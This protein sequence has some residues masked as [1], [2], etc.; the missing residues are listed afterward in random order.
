MDHRLVGVRSA[1]V[2]A[3]RLACSS[4]KKNKLLP[5]HDYEM[6][7]DVTRSRGQTE[8]NFKRTDPMKPINSDFNVSDSDE[9][10]ELNP[11]I[12][13]TPPTS[14]TDDVDES[15]PAAAL[16]AKHPKYLETFLKR[17]RLHYLSS[18][19]VAKKVFVQELRQSVAHRQLIETRREELRN[20]LRR[21]DRDYLFKWSDD[22]KDRIYMHID[23]D[24]FFV[25]VA[26]RNQPELRDQ[27]I[28][29]THSKGTKSATTVCDS[30]ER[31]DAS[32]PFIFLG[33]A[34]ILFSLGIGIV[35][36]CR[37]QVRCSKWHV[38]R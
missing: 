21:T 25:A 37:S 38:F 13:R 18:T 3:H 31:T 27:P 17:S 34:T 33:R 12:E 14:E 35:Q 28:A 2:S 20:K 22:K 23:M 16:D 6:Y 32:P 30:R 8:L 29:I 24:C 1:S 19:A 7:K 4:I 15:D 36:L 11:P 5:T 26:T 9:D 10:N